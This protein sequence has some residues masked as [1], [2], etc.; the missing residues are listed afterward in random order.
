[1][2]TNALVPIIIKASN[3]GVVLYGVD[4]LGVW[5]ALENPTSANAVRTDHPQSR[6]GSGLLALGSGLFVTEDQEYVE[7]YIN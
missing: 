1:M 4:E 2:D 3:E 6:M 7:I 5:V